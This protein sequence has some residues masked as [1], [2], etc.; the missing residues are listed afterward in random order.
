MALAAVREKDLGEQLPP[1]SQVPTPGRKRSQRQLL[2]AGWECRGTTWSVG[3]V[4]DGALS[5]CAGHGPA[6]V[7]LLDDAPN[8]GVVTAL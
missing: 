3:D 6:D 7:R 1:L 4:P 5:N 8:D 2:T